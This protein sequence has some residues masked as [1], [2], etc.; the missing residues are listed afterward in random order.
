M[1]HL[2]ETGENPATKTPEEE[3][4]AQGSK[5]VFFEGGVASGRG[6]RQTTSEGIDAQ[7]EADS[8]QAD[9]LAT[10]IKKGKLGLAGD[11][12]GG[13]K[14]SVEKSEMEKQYDFN[15]GVAEFAVSQNDIPRFQEAYIYII[16]RDISSDKQRIAALDEAFESGNFDDDGFGYRVGDDEATLNLERREHNRRTKEALMIWLRTYENELEK[17]KTNPSVII[18]KYSQPALRHRESLIKGEKSL[19]LLLRLARGLE[20]GLMLKSKGYHDSDEEE[21][22]S[23]FMNRLDGAIS[24]ALSYTYKDASVITPILAR[25]IY[26]DKRYPS[27]PE[28]QK[29][30]EKL[31]VKQAELGGP[32]IFQGFK[33][34][35]RRFVEAV[36]GE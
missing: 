16:E 20:F 6:E 22:L 26:I 30:I 2:G 13:V 27:S 1:P 31:K 7:G 29:W 11:T 28:L 21:K 17:V 15:V 18:E 24:T 10:E 25:L 33:D 5:S 35:M 14:D 19:D 8:V 9:A 36:K 32:S 4:L 12:E 23:Y 3:R 34:R